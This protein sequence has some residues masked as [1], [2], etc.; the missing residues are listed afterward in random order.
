MQIAHRGRDRDPQ[1]TSTQAEDR[2]RGRTADFAFAAGRSFSTDLGAELGKPGSPATVMASAPDGAGAHADHEP[3]A[4]GCSQRRL[5]LQ[6]A[7]VAGKG[8]KAIRGIPV[9]T[10]GEPP[11][12]C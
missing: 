9:R 8:P 7:V 5:A 6:E 2:S 3:A 10:V 11:A 12:S 1:Q 4:G